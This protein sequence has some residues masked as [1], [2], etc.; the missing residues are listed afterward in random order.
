MVFQI[1]VG[2]G[3]NLPL[4]VEIVETLGSVILFLLL[5]LANVITIYSLNN[6]FAALFGSF[7]TKT[8]GYSFAVCGFAQTPGLFKMSYCGTLSL[9]STC[10]KLLSRISLVWIVLELVKILTLFGAIGLFKTR[11]YRDEGTI[12]CI[13]FGQKGV[14]VDR[15]W[16]NVFAGMLIFSFRLRSDSIFI[17]QGFSELIFGTA[18]GDVRSEFPLDITTAVMSAQIVGAVQNGDTMAGAGYA[19]DILTDCS[20]T[21][22]VDVATIMEV[23]TVSNAT[24]SKMFTALGRLPI[25]GLVN[26][27]ESPSANGSI[28]ITTLLAQ[29]SVCGGTNNSL[30]PVCTTTLSNHVNARVQATYMTDGTPASI[31]IQKVSVRERGSEGNMTWV[32]EAI[33]N[34][35]GGVD[36]SVV[37]PS[38]IPGTMNPL[39]WW[40]TPNLLTIDP[41][42]LNAGLETTFAILLR[43]G[44]QRTFSLSGQSCS[45]N[46][47]ISGYS[48]VIMG[49]AENKIGIFVYAFQLFVSVVSFVAFVPWLI[50]THPM[51]PGIR[52]LKD[53]SYFMTLMNSSTSISGL[54]ELA[55]A[56]THM[57][58]QA[59]DLVLRV[60]ESIQT[61]SEEV[62]HI[63]VEK[64][65]LVREMVNGKRYY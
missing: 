55:N 23:S 27:V 18:L 9:N 8:K 54:H 20:C 35:L 4:D 46:I 24:A 14:P 61:T 1:K 26:H 34:V 15:G 52:V 25:L 38:T 2:E 53:K 11:L 64:P 39:L 10:R 56:Q 29:T 50:S 58:W 3:M 16:P 5:L 41:A 43:A 62:G 65:K 13:E 63:A 31:A 42:L 40:T 36:S 7:L 49:D 6:G 51:G 45:K 48:Y 47:A 33:K 44:M 30:V 21:G 60:G 57:I 37:L 19:T 12:S 28:I 59:L 22:E 17:E 32:Y